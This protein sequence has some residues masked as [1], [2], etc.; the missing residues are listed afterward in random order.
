MF[1]V[2]IIKSDVLPIFPV[3]GRLFLLGSIAIRQQSWFDRLDLS[4]FC[5]EFFCHFRVFNCYARYCLF[6]VGLN[7][8][9][10]ALAQFRE[11][12]WRGSLCYGACFYQIRLLTANGAAM[13]P[14]AKERRL[15]FLDCH[16]VPVMDSTMP[17]VSVAHAIDIER[18]GALSARKFLASPTRSN[19]L[20]DSS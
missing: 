16:P 17:E 10:R 15:K 19:V 5:L 6:G 9:S 14:R 13:K 4:L 18:E 20:F 7:I 11:D 1:E 12:V 3:V 8:S 2:V